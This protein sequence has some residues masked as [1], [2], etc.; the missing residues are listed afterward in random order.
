MPFVPVPNTIGVQIRMSLDGQF[1]ENTLYFYS[2]SGVDVAV[3]TALGNELLLWWTTEYS[4]ELA[5]L[6]S[7]REIYLVDLSSETGPTVTIPA[8][9]P[10]PV[11]GVGADALPNNCAL[12]ISF[13]AAKRGR[14]YRGRNYVSGLP[15]TL[16]TQNEANTLLTGALVDAYNGLFTRAATAAV[17]WVVVSRFAGGLPRV[18]GN[19]EPVQSVVLVDNVVDSQRRRLPGRGR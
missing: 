13:R 2:G 14:A 10:A 1:I 11:G 9:A 18:E 17:T 6:L 16:V 15:D 3:M 12:C 19:A 7:L 8:P 4:S 5:S